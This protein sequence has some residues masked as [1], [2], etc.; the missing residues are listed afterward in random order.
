M[1]SMGHAAELTCQELVELVTDYLENA[2]P[3]SEAAR[4]EEHLQNC[5]GCRAYVEQMRRT[6]GALGRLREDWI[7]EDAIQKLLHTFRDWKRTR[8]PE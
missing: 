6:V 3:R 5:R 7:P 8:P 4:F 1:S 2:L